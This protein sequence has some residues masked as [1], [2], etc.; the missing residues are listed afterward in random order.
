ML[1]FAN[2]F[3][4]DERRKEKKQSALFLFFSC[5]I[6][7]LSWGRRQLVKKYMGKEKKNDVHQQTKKAIL[8]WALENLFFIYEL[9]GFFLVEG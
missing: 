3:F 5:F 1:R 9:E 2:Y 6:F 7:Y 8:K 4:G